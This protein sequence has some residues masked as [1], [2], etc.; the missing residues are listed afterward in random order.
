MFKNYLKIAWRSLIKSKWYTII[1]I[2]GLALGMAGA[3]LILLWIQH[4]A[5]YDQFHKNNNR[6]YEAFYQTPFDGVIR[7]GNYTSEP[8]GP[9]LKAEFPE[10]QAS[11]RYNAGIDLLLKT[12]KDAINVP[13][14]FVDRPF[15]E[16]FSFPLVL[17]DKNTALSQPNSIILSQSTAQLFFGKENALGKTIK[18]ENEYVATVT[19]ILK[20]LPTNTR[21]QLDAVCNWDFRTQMGFEDQSPHAWTNSVVNTFVLLKPHTSVAAFNAKVK[22][23]SMRKDEMSQFETFLYPLKKWHLYN[24]F[25]NGKVIG[26]RID[27]LYL[28]GAIAGFILIIACINFT[29]LST[30]RSERRAKEVG[31]R[32]V[33]GAYKSLL[34]KQFLCESILLAFFA[35]CI[36]LS[37][38]WL[39]LPLYQSIIG[40]QVQVPLNE[41][42]FWVSAIGFILLAGLLAGS[43]PAFFLSSFNPISVLKGQ[44][45]KP[46]AH[47][48]PRKILVVIQFGF[49]ITLIIC[50]LIVRQQ[51]S[52]AINRDV[53]YH[54]DQLLTIHLNDE[55][56]KKGELIRQEL[57]NSGTALSVTKTGNAM[58][59]AYNSSWGIDWEGKDPNAKIVLYRYGADAD[60]IKTTGVQLLAGRDI[61]VYQYPSD[62]TAIILNETAANVMGFDNPIGKVVDDNLIKWTIVGVVKDF[63]I[64]SPYQ[65]IQPMLIEGPAAYLPIMTVRMNG[66]NKMAKNLSSVEDIFKK[67]A[68]NYPVQYEFANEDYA[69]KFKNEQKT[70]LLTGI[71]SGISILISCLGLFA[72]A[73]YMAEIRQKEI[74]VRKV[75]GATISS[76]VGLL[77]RE[78]I[79]LVLIA[80]AIA[81]PIAYYFMNK[82]LYDFAYKISIG[83]TVFAWTMLITIAIALL[84]V[85]YQA[86][87]AALS[88]PVDSLRNE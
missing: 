50:T 72:L 63:V 37:L 1:N 76:L 86:I 64:Q 28:F 80:F 45:V 82:W 48:S 46:K 12:D 51:I 29:N 66:A 27:N 30:A 32:K 61:N 17:G 22:D 6:L 40:E 75:L 52:F 78:F 84:T 83:W 44:M 55:S 74:G 54:Q 3:V 7:T 19:G 41:P 67:Y 15:F 20:D 81:A 88:N 38:V 11:S 53:G 18:I 70:A 10:V 56:M 4:E 21:F 59:R 24:R 9:A 43:Y 58:T 14:T 65:K 36:A 34:V 85:S 13:L 69:A 77:S 87:K 47:F 42:L 62:S 79:I 23:I 39:A 71:F 33:A 5:S 25:E 8:M 60:F 31:V 49:A 68:P 2:S 73:A 35:G 26:G 57:I 16:M